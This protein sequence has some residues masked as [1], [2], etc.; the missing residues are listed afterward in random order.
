ML[1]ERQTDFTYKKDETIYKYSA[2]RECKNF[3]ISFD[4]FEKLCDLKLSVNVLAS[5]L[6]G[7]TSRLFITM[8]TVGLKKTNV[9]EIYVVCDKWSTRYF[10]IR[11]VKSKSH[12][13]GSSRYK[14]R[15]NFSHDS[16][17][18]PSAS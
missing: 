13:N 17:E 2:E 18:R 5:F 3:R 6:E 8:D 14:A 12:E 4:L 15:L 7:N 9:K 10:A 11:H 1:I 16:V